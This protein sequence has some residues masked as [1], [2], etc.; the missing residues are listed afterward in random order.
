MNKMWEAKE[1]SEKTQVIQYPKS[2]EKWDIFEITLYSSIKYEN[3]FRQVSLWG[4]FKSKPAC[5]SN[6]YHQGQ[7]PGALCHRK[8]A[9]MHFTFFPMI[10]I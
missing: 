3:P 6:M 5:T 9:N 8:Q 2:V 7:K 1:I 10:R 4:E